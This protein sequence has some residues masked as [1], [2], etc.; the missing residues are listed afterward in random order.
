MMKIIY[1]F[2]VIGVLLV[3]SLVSCSSE[4]ED[5]HTTLDDKIK[6]SEA[7][8]MGAS[9]KAEI[10]A[11]EDYFTGYNSLSVILY[12]SIN[13]NS[14]IT[15]ASVEFKPVMTM[16]MG[17]GTMMHSC[18]VENPVKAVD[19]VYQGAVVFIMPSSTDGIWKMNLTVN[20][21]ESN[22]SGTASF[23]ITVNDPFNSLMKSFVA[24]SSDSSKLFVS[25]LKPVEWK[26]GTNDLEF[27]IH[28]K[29]SMMSFPADSTYS[30]EFV[31][32]MPSMGHGSPNNVNPL[33]MG[34]GHYKGKVNFTMTGEW[35][36]NVNIL[37][38]GA[39]VSNGLFFNIVF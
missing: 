16:N 21:P 7:Y 33:S 27:T 26:V 2:W 8:I 13:P 31:P 24:Q 11:D 4:K 19:G 23:E 3:V 18:P 30:I 17:T 25:F 9:M 37:K 20:Q 34:N 6:L 14:K 32:E 29:T 5:I 38:N 15:N 28:K 22:K 39:V 36:L 1:I 35:K 12:D 10:W